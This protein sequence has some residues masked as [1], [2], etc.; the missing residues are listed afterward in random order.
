MI[1]KYSAFLL[2]NMDLKPFKRKGRKELI[3][4]ALRNFAF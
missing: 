4:S 2:K 1:I 3:V